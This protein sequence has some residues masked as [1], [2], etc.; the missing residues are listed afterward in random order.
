MII[1]AGYGC[2][3]LVPGSWVVAGESHL[4]HKRHVAQTLDPE[5]L[6]HLPRKFSIKMSQA[7]FD[8]V[9]LSGDLVRSARKVTGET[10]QAAA[11][12]RKD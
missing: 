4:I 11:K 12:D 1:I 10:E 9:N 7:F 8:C 5:Q 6:I 3:L 2:Y